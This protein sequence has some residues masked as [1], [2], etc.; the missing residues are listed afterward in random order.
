[1][2]SVKR[3]TY[4]IEVMSHY[5]PVGVRELARLT[6]LDKSAV[7]RILKALEE[8]EFIM[9]SGTGKYILSPKLL[10]IAN[11]SVRNFA[12]KERTEGHLQELHR[13]TR[14]TVFMGVLLQNDIFYIHKIKS[15]HPTVKA[16]ELDIIAEIGYRVPLYNSS[17]GKAILAFLDPTKQEQLIKNIV[18]N[19]VT[20]KTIISKRQLKEELEITRQRGYAINDEELRDG[21]RGVGAPVLNFRGEVIGSVT[22]TAPVSRMNEERMLEYGRLLTRYGAK[23]SF[24]LGYQKNLQFKVLEN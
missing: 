4:I 8:A 20:Q 16:E 12:I 5:G 10:E 11:L 7:S 21:F 24:D 17:S 22:I 3:A 23:M 18:I 19:K 6:N 13:L 2:S 9:R 1:M 14:E 15:N